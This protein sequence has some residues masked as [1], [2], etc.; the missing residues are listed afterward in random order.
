MFIY[1][2]MIWEL[3]PY[4]K[5]LTAWEREGTWCLEL[6]AAEASEMDAL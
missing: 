3:R 5:G 1:G 6:E 4:S 2:M